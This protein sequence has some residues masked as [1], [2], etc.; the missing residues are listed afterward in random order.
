M[1]EGWEWGEESHALGVVSPAHACCLL[2][3]SNLLE[4]IHANALVCS[5]KIVVCQ[6]RR[7]SSKCV[8]GFNKEPN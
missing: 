7:S 5:S 2:E 6:Q 1:C 3:Q 8:H 4:A